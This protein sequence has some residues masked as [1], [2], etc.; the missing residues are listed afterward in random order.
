MKKSILIGLCI[1]LTGC[2]S[3]AALKKLDARLAVQE[4]NIKVIAQVHNQLSSKTTA[5]AERVK[6]NE[7][8]ATL[9][10][11]LDSSQEVVYGDAAYT[12]EKPCDDSEGCPGET[13]A[14]S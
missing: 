7:E 8:K 5:L 12:I 2:A 6:Q 9:V 3:N 14:L 11:E 13:N 4:Q 10:K 1:F